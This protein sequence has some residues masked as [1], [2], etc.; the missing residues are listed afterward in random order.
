MEINWD[1]NLSEFETKIDNLII[2]LNSI[3]KNYSNYLADINGKPMIWWV[4][5]QAIKVKEFNAV[6]VATDDKRIEKICK[7][8]DINVIM[9]STSHISFKRD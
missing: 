8:Y 5:Q 2:G 4:Y 1:T 7:D 9:T 3:S 6:Y